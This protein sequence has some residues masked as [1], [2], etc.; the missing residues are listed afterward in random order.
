MVSFFADFFSEGLEYP[1]IE[2]HSKKSQSSRNT[3][4]EHFKRT[5]NGILFTSDLVNCVLLI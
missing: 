3:A 5:K 2:L 1:V 4:S